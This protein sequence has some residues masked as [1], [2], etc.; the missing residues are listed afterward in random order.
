MILPWTR[1]ALQRLLAMRG[2]LP[3]ALLIH[4]PAGIG[5]A[6]LARQF[7][8]SLLC[9]QPLDDGDACGRCAACGWFAQSNHPD[10]RLLTPEAEDE[11]AVA[12]AKTKP[13][14][15]IR[16]QQVRALAE[17]LSIGAHRAGRKVV[18]VSPADAM[19]VPAA[20]ALLKTLEEPP[21][22]TVF[23]LVSGRADALPATIRS[24]CVAIGLPLPASD[25][26]LAWL[27]VQAAGDTAQAAAALAAAG[28]APL[29]AATL[30][31]PAQAALQRG[32]L[33]AIEALP[34]QSVL[35]AAEI[36]SA[37][38]A[39]HWLALLLAWVTDLARVGA[40]AAPRRF[41]G[42]AQRLTR[43][44]GQCSLARLS[45]YA[46]WLTRQ[47]ALVEHPLNPRLLAEDCLLRYAALF[48][49][50]TRN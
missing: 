7:A 39:R 5:K 36:L 41:P 29:R 27:S 4:G 45:D 2:S 20:N 47:Q 24:R 43:L 15:D 3:H 8:A 9:E 12:S 37:Q 17:F 33:E 18:L 14:R 34:E 42:Q 6:G 19:N 10:F 50:R 32:L 48:S 23:L 46:S 26:A 22:D 13:S 16:I 21:G 28:G 35:R 31:E 49:A 40:G 11:Q 30:L 1:P 38:P 44:A 25:E